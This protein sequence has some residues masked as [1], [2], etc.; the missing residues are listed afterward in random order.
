MRPFHAPLG[1]RRVRIENIYVQLAQ[2]SA[3]LSHAFTAGRMRLRYAE[4]RM[5]VAVEGDRLTMA[6]KIFACRLEISKGALARN[7]LQVYQLARRIVD[8]HQ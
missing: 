4:Y 6:L 8:E 1:L 3:E 7:E 2:G 5:L